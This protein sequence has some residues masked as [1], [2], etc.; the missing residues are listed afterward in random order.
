MDALSD[1]LS[2]VKFRGSLYFTTEFSSP[3][4]VHVPAF[5]NVARFH[6][7]MRGNCFAR[8]GDREEPVELSPG[9]F[10]VIPHGAAHELLDCADGKV[11]VL[12]RVLEDSGYDGK[13]HLAYGLKDEGEETRLI[14]GHFAFDS[15]SHH[16]MLSE[17]PDTIKDDKA[18]N[19]YYLCLVCCR[20]GQVEMRYDAVLAGG[21]LQIA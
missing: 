7:V 17:L 18:R 19:K 3:W 12:D 5:S 20:R 6:L 15:T 10:I 8:V 21:L 14:C 11:I 9:D 13:G 4:G 16:P 1:I 2:H